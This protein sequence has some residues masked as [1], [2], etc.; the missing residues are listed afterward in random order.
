MTFKAD[1]LQRRALLNRP[2]AQRMTNLPTEKVGSDSV[3][4]LGAALAAR[5]S[6]SSDRP[7]Q[8][9]AEPPFHPYPFVC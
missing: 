4:A 3:A 6:S 2:Q 1:P 9:R 5:R 8:A 7:W